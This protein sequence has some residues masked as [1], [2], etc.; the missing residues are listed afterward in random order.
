MP[1]ISDPELELSMS[2]PNRYKSHS[3]GS[4]RDLYETV[5]EVPH[6][7]QGQGLGNFSTD[8]PRSDELL[9][10]PEKTPQRGGNSEILYWMEYTIIQI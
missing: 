6:G 9:A 8:P 3:E 2:N 5:Q 10:H 1:I 7:V 4:N